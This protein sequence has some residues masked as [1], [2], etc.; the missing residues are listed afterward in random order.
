MD[1]IELLAVCD[2][3]KDYGLQL[4]AYARACGSF[5]FRIQ[6]FTSEAML[7][8]YRKGR[9]VD[10]V[11]LEESLYRPENWKDYGGALF[12]LGNGV[13]K[14]AGLPRLYKY[15]PAG[16][17]LAELTAEYSSRMPRG[18][19]R[20]VSKRKMDIHGIYSPVGRCG[21]SSFALALGLE[22]A[23]TEQVLYLN[24]EAWPALEGLCGLQGEWTVSDFLYLLRERREGLLEQLQ[25]MLVQLG[26]LE[27]L[28]PA[29]SPADLAVVP[30]GDWRYF[31][32]QLRC[33]SGYTA[34]VLDIGDCLQ[35]VEELL[36]LCT[37]VWLPVR[38]EPEAREKLE[39]FTGFL[40]KTCGPELG[41]GFTRLRLPECPEAAEPKFYAETLL[42]GPMGQF[43]RRL[44]G[45]EGDEN[46]T[47]YTAA[48]KKPGDNA[49]RKR[50][51]HGRRGTAAD[52][53]ADP[54]GR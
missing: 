4:S 44:L 45:R 43:V 46:G 12:L 35:P 15:Q 23:R 24:L 16:D 29:Q 40:E 20:T 13:G 1:Q 34:V 36:A 17:L 54:R 30:P 21:K 47:D 39:R 33:Y 48:S 5:S 32:D 7:Q 49:G 38:D 51:L 50:S 8:D 28:C 19:K 14:E 26:R 42:W 11:L 52:R 2:E 31:F 18:R 41:K 3:E 37:T 53:P 22:L 9:E 10:A 27:L 25:L 6:P